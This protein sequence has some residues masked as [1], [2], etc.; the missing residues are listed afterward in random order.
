MRV[1]P[2]PLPDLLSSLN[3]TQLEATEAALQISTGRSVNVPSDNPA[4]AA[5]LV[6]NN[7]EATFNT[8]YLSD[9]TAVSS[10]LSAAD[11]TLSSVQ[12]ALQ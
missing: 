1:N 11:S 5:Q 8:G 7:D 4:A 12:S 2:Y 6:V 9:L 10:Q 3:Q